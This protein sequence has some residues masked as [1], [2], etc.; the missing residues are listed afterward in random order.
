MRKYVLFTLAFAAMAMFANAARTIDWSTES[1]TAPD[2][3]RSTSTSTLFNIGVVMKNNGTDTVMA[4]DTLLFQFAVSTITPAQTILVYPSSTTL[5]L[6][7][8]NKT[9]APGDTMMLSLSLTANLKIINSTNVRITLISHI[10]N[11]PDVGFEG[12]STISNNT[13]TKDVPWYNEHGWSV[14]MKAAEAYT[15]T[16]YPNPVSDVLNIDVN[17]TSDKVVTLYDLAGRKVDEVAFT[18]N[19]TTLNVAR[20]NRGLYIYEVKMTDGQLLKTGRVSVK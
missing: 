4:G 14:G 1:F 11:R 20:Y 8:V 3:I 2:S 18:G 15:T 7:V 16:V 9:Y 5:A 17:N 6:R 12:A 19:H 10:V 13:K